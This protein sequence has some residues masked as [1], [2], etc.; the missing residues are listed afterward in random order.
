MSKVRSI[1]YKL[2]A[3]NFQTRIAPFLYQENMLKQVDDGQI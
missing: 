3:Y 1:I 2:D